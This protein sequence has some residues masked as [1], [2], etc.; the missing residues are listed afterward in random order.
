MLTPDT[1]LQQSIAKI[2]P[3]ETVEEDV[4][5]LEKLGAA[6]QTENVIGSFLTND[7]E[8]SDYDPNFNPWE[9]LTDEEKLDERFVD[10][11]LEANSPSDLDSVR[12][13]SAKERE[14]R[15]K[16]TG[17]DGFVSIMAA[18][19]LDPVSFIP[20]GGAAYKTYRT[21]GS[22]LKG[23][24]VTGAVTSGAVGVQEALL[25]SQQV[26]RTFGESAVNIT[27]AG[28]LSAVLGSAAAGL[29]KAQYKRA[30]T[31]IEQDM[32]IPD[33]VGASSTKEAVEIKGT[34]AKKLIAATKFDPLSRLLTSKSQSS[35]RVISDL[36]ENPID[37]DGYTGQAV[38]S[39]I[40][41]RRDGMLYQGVK[42]NRDHYKAYLKEVGAGRVKA[43]FTDKAMSLREFNEAVG[44]EVRNPTTDNVHVRNAAN[45]WVS[46]VY[47]PQFAD[48]KAN[49]LLGDDVEIN[50]ADRYLNRVWKKEAIA[51]QWTLF[52]SRV[53]SWLMDKG[54]QEAAARDTAEEIGARIMSSHDG[55]LPYNYE[56]GT[57]AKGGS[58]GGKS[59]R[60]A[61]FKQ[62]VF[63]IPDDMVEEFLEN[64]IED[65]AARYLRQTSAD[66]EIMA[67]FGDA[68][69]PVE[70]TL[71]FTPQLKEIE[72]DYL[73]LIDNAK[74]EKTVRRLNKELN[75]Q[76]KDLQGV[77][78]RIRGRYFPDSRT[79]G[80]NRF[81]QATRNLNFLRL[82]GGV[83]VSSI[84]DF[85]RLV[86]SEGLYRA[87]KGSFDELS[88]GLRNIEN[89]PAEDIRYFGIGTDAYIG[90]R[91]EVIADINDY[92]VGGNALERGLQSMANSF[93]NINLMNQWT[94]G[95]KT[96]HAISM[97]S[98]I[99][100]QAVKGKYPKQLER[101]GISSSDLTRIK[102]QVKKHGYK[103]GDAWVYNAK[104]WDD[105]ALAMQWGA[106]LKKESDRVIVVPGQE[107]P[108]FM[109]RELGKTVMQFKS[110]MM[111]ATQRVTIAAIQ[112]Q[113]AHLIQGALSM[114][115]VGAMVSVLKNM[116]AGREV[117][118]DPQA[119]IA[120]GIDRSGALGIF[121]EI[122]NTMEKVS[123]G[124]FGIRP[125]MGIDLPA[126]RYASRSMSETVLG[127]TFGSML[128]TGFRVMVAATDEGEWGESDTRA[129]RR[130]L[131]Y[132]NLTGFRRGLDEIEKTIHD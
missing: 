87:F 48:M 78:D 3:R 20:F 44:R 28:F 119:L 110:F 40:K 80:A 30:I 102:A 23:A 125:S 19:V 21:G 113:D 27:A 70:S 88:R 131:P 95:I 15:A 93:G 128:N 32:Q 73:R 107:K 65:L 41:V 52:T 57:G 12:V 35:R 54:M 97:Q 122:N 7:L 38:E 22:I 55:M 45:D 108:L 62:R 117:D 6:F 115:S 26:E 8:L 123:N 81:L 109:S 37:V 11:A 104:E 105:P 111:S 83:T 130:L 74:D 64:D 118:L 49:R 42:A 129:V 29:S 14:A 76:K 46:K 39:L 50:T 127:P 103:D 53:S 90:G 51:G 68:K 9:F 121:M 96:I 66:I 5:T 24:A 120:E 92:T 31:Q 126:S 89:A 17:V 58:S 69:D 82:M 33:S 86:M 61:P 2:V 67:R 36:A 85:G 98:R 100:D 77:I 63:K 99:M 84:P 56:I 16:L 79:E 18:G 13:Q 116:E 114:I 106:A 71:S 60:A 72:D 75:D 59:G 112:Q 47:D 4:S 10:T 91:L 1:Q 124:H 101:L 94:G 132:Q 43:K 25:H 34:I